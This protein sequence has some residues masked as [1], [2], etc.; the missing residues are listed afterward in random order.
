MASLND[1]E[2]IKKSRQAAEKTIKDN[3]IT[4][5]LKSKLK[6]FEKIIHLE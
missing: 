4:P 2:L 3:L 5:E 6:E 1:L